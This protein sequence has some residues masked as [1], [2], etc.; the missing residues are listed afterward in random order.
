MEFIFPEYFAE[1]VEKLRRFHY[2]MVGSLES[3]KRE[4]NLCISQEM[5]RLYA[6][7]NNNKSHRQETKKKIKPFCN[8]EKKKKRRDLHH[9]KKEHTQGALGQWFSAWSR[10][11]CTPSSIPMGRGALRHVIGISA[12]RPRAQGR[13]KAEGPNSSSYK[14]KNKKK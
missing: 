2:H 14:I 8:N 6:S 7:S 13:I 4:T 5:M 9:K 11:H 1:I 12:G 10:F 3:R